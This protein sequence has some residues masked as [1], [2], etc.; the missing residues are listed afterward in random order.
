MVEDN[1]YQGLANFI[2]GV[3]LGCKEKQF[4]VHGFHLIEW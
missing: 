2:A 1:C 4:G 3:V